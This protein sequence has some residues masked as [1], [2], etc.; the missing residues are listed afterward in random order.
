VGHEVLPRPATG[1]PT[2]GADQNATG[3]C[4]SHL[5]AVVVSAGRSQS[6]AG[7]WPY[8]RARLMIVLGVAGS[9]VFAGKTCRSYVPVV[10]F[11]LALVPLA[12]L[13]ANAVAAVDL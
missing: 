1:A 11:A 4:A 13:Y 5:C 3:R 7:D 9:R 8:L 2:V 12:D 6:L 10:R